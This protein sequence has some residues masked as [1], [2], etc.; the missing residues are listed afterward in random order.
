MTKIKNLFSNPLSLLICLL[1]LA[2]LPRGIELLNHNYLWGFD[3]G[4][5]YLAV[6]EI[7]I[8]KNP[9]LIG[10]QV[11]G[12]GGFFQ[13]PGWYYLLSIPFVLF[14]GDPYGGMILMF[15]IGIATVGFAFHFMRK[16]FDIKTAFVVAF[17]I[18][19]SPEII[20]YSR[21]IW[22]P[23]PV[24]LLSIFYLYFLYKLINGEKKYLV[25]VT[26][27]IGL[28]AHFEIAT[29]GTLLIQFILFSP[30]LFWKKL[31]SL[32]FL[33][34]SIISFAFTL[35]PLIFFDLRNNHLILNGIL[36]LVTNKNV[37]VLPFQ[38]IVDNHISVF[39]DNFFL[40]LY[41]AR[42]VWQIYIAFFIFGLFFYLRDKKKTLSQKLFVSYLA[43]SPIVLFLIFLIYKQGI[44]NWWIIELPITYC[45]LL[46]ILLAQFLNKSGGKVFVSVVL[47][48]FMVSY[49]KQTAFWYKNDFNDYGG[50]AKIKG[51]IDALDYIYK[52][53][54]EEKFGLLVF[55]PPI[56]TYP[57][58]YLV[59]WY[60]EKKY[61]YRPHSEKKGTFY[62]LIEPDPH[63][64]WTYE[65]WLETV[66][67]TGRILET[68]ELPSGFIIQK[69]VEDETI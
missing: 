32:K 58:E 28:M 29:A 22:P 8:D 66:I 59:W 5:H 17:L 57:Y 51:K 14:G 44:W 16:M 60:G 67:K 9:T 39:K 55:S 52:D 10:T 41:N 13:G 49:I 1:V 42:E 48:F 43:L 19:I 64:P 31:V 4:E 53:A 20:T 23:F 34:L 68:T 56:Y 40:T 27:V 12:S 50:T 7:V 26:F 62:L 30:V 15:L 61:G 21:F 69:R 24:A 54:G 38:W 45:F 11:G 2:A 33:V 25:F 3:Q 18:A 46:G 6:K 47:I 37:V 36:N 65:G 35:S 63:Q